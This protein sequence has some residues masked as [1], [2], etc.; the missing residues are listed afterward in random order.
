MVFVFD[1]DDTIC[2]TD[3]YSEK[4]I[5]KFFKQHNMPY[6]QI[7]KVVR[8]A[9]KK[10]DWSVE[11]ANSW[12]KQFGDQM[13]LEFPYK[14]NSVKIINKL[15]NLGHTIIIATARAN[16]WHTKPEEITKQWLN[17]VGLKY[18]KLYVGRID[19]E[20]ICEEENA[21][22]FIDDEIKYVQNAANYFN[23][24]KKCQSFLMTTSYN[25]SLPCP[26]NVTRVKN[27]NEFKNELKKFGIKI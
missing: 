17:K 12:Y 20:K 6:K 18:S 1:L 7:A 9:E 24:N 3:E 11:E 23:G 14:K 5:N 4:Y 21:N 10:F 8:F 25:L 16:D 26:P 19:K 27:F 15:F 2:K 13:M 22:F